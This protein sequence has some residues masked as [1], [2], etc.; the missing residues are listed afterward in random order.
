MKADMAALAKEIHVQAACAAPPKAVLAGCCAPAAP[1]DADVV[2]AP[3]EEWGPFVGGS[4]AA[5]TLEAAS[6]ADAC[7]AKRV[8]ALESRMQQLGA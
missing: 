3:A 1:A 4:A 7:C 5:T 6:D 2:E 8:E